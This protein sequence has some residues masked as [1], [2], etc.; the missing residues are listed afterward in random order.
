MN[1]N[2]YAAQILPGPVVTGPGCAPRMI[3]SA[4]SVVRNF[5]CEEL[6]PVVRSFTEFLRERVNE[7]VNEIALRPYRK[8]SAGQCASSL[9]KMPSS[10]P[11]QTQTV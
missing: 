4:A 3:L 1:S 8:E 2:F 7:R 11:F 9:L 5:G 6:F 10:A